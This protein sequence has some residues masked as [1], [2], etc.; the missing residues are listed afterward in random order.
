MLDLRA[1]IVRALKQLLIAALVLAVLGGIGGLLVMISGIVPIK[2]SSGHW[3]ITAA[4]LDFAKRR[5]VKT[6]T[7]RMKVPPLDDPALALKGAGHYDFA[8]EP[9]HGSPAVQQPRIAYRMTPTPPDLLK[10]VPTYY[11]EE[12]FYIVKHGIKFTGMPSWPSQQRDDEVWAMVAFLRKLPEL[13]AAKY[14]ELTGATKA[15]PDDQLPLEDLTGP[16]PPMP[17][18]VA[19]NCARC[20]GIDGLGRGT[21]AFPRLAGQRYE[22]L[23]GSL[24][25]YARG[26]RHSG[27]MEPVAANLGADDIEAISRYYAGLPAPGPAAAAT[28]DPEIDFGR[29]IASEGIPARLIPA[30]SECHGPGQRRNPNYPRLAGQYANYLQLQLEVYR[31]KRRGGTEYHELM[32]KFVGQLTDEQ[33]R[34]VTKYYASLPGERGGETVGTGVAANR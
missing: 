23:S 15:A 13:D 5:S 10:T 24:L 7:F 14:D 28:T 19:E 3:D 32:H 6:H 8:C 9:C 27:I 18:A 31:D 2:A 11:P 16:S 33:I 26:Q 1:R 17:D 22:Y 12:L 21:G 20:H 29:R 30:C 34:A 4:F 25:A